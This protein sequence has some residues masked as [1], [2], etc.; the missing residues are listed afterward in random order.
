MKKQL[1]QLVL[2]ASIGI[3]F[4]FIIFIINQ[5]VQVVQL[6]RSFHPMAGTVTAY[7]LVI[8]YA[9]IIFVMVYQFL[10]LPRPL[11]FPGNK[12][13]N[14]YCKFLS[15][16]RNRLLKNKALPSHL[17]NI[18]IDPL[19]PG[20]DLDALEEHI[21][22]AEQELDALAN[23]EIKTTAQMV[24]L[25]TAVSQSGSLDSFV[26]LFAQVKMI[27][28]IA[29]L[30]NQRP[31]LRELIMLYAN[32]A[33][34]SYAARALEEL[35]FAEIIEPVIQSFGRV[36]FLNF[37]PIIS[38]V[39]N[40]LFN[41]ATNALLTLRTGIITRKYCSLFSHFE[42]RLAYPDER[43]LKRNIKLSA[44]REAGKQLGGVII[45][46]SQTV[47]KLVLKGLKRS[48]EYSG[49]MAEEMGKATKEVINRII[50]FFKRKN[51]E[52]PL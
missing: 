42:T 31:A 41:G 29:R 9:L 33:V 8:I 6:A 34:T 43:E 16:T 21:K 48:K 28:R 1:K 36:G 46:P 24:F 19:Q 51:H 15:G 32:V 40:S 35:D 38:I 44:I 10:H 13:S 26:V 37:I 25:S 50:D 7:F 14:D 5:T 39:S 22:Q 23:R 47:L 27:W 45:T 2:A 11:K 12:K 52:E 4:L 3:I 20:A 49:K 30:Y 18:S 17:R